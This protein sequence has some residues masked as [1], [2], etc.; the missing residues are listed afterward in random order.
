MGHR[1]RGRVF[2]NLMSEC[3]WKVEPSLESQKKRRNQI[4]LEL[5]TAITDVLSMLTENNDNNINNPST[6]TSTT[7][8]YRRMEVVYS[9][10]DRGQNRGFYPC[11]STKL[12]QKS[13]G[14]I[15]RSK[16][17]NKGIMPTEME[18]VL[19]YTQQGASHEVSVSTEGVEE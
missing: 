19:E 15:K 13:F 18:L 2:S 3:G 16:C 5:L 9:F 17:E 11:T 7:K 8:T 14:M 12:V 1:L 4:A 10:L 6:S